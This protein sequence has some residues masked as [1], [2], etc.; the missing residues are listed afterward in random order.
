MER[1]EIYKYKYFPD[2]FA[3]L[4]SYYE[5]KKSVKNHFA[6]TSTLSLKKDHQGRPSLEGWSGDISL[7]HTEGCILIG[8]VNQGKIGVDIQRIE[9]INDGVENF[10][11]SKRERDYLYSLPS[12][13]KQ[14]YLFTIWTLKEALLK[15]QGS[16]FLVK[17]P[18]DISLSLNHAFKEVLAIE[19]MEQIQVKFKLF[20]LFNRYQAAICYN[21]LEGVAGISTFEDDCRF[22]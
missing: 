11:L 4:L 13:D 9:S 2:Q 15:W 21:D 6:H 14:K 19:G 5:A 17:S 16:G 18:I 1:D 20:T 3:A 12:E 8:A 10:F 22:T 7:S